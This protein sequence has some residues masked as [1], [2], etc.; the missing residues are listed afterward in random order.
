MGKVNNFPQKILP[1]QIFASNINFNFEDDSGMHVCCA[2]WMILAAF[3][4]T[5]AGTDSRTPP[6]SQICC[7]CQGSLKSKYENLLIKKSIKI[8]D[9]LRT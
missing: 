9:Y 3:L 6:G 2:F 7:C 4:I 8:M 5:Y 1:I